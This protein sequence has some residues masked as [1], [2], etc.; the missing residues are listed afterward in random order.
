MCCVGK[1][2]FT[3]HRESERREEEGGERE[4]E[5][6]EEEGKRER[7]DLMNL[8]DALNAFI[9]INRHGIATLNVTKCHNEQTQRMSQMS[10][11]KRTAYRVRATSDRLWRWIASC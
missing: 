4:G 1:S 11:K 8:Q 3:P 6:E 5:E 7:G 2:A 9:R 10:H